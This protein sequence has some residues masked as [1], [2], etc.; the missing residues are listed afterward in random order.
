[1]RGIAIRYS[2]GSD[3]KKIAS[4]LRHLSLSQVE[5]ALTWH[6]ANKAEIDEEIE[7]EDREATALEALHTR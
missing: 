1:V 3:A 7:D 5:A 2:T 4:R 6:F